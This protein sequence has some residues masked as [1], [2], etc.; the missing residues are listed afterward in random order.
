VIGRVL[1]GAA[2]AALP[3]QVAYSRYIGHQAVTVVM[4]GEGPAR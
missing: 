3:G 2:A 4:S 1:S